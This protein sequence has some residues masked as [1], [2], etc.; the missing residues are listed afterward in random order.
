VTVASFLN[1]CRACDQDFA[2]LEAFDRHRVGVHQYTFQEGMRMVPSREDG[3]R[4]LHP[5]EM[6]GRGMS[7]NPMGRWQIDARVERAR[8]A[9]SAIGE[10]SGSDR[11]ASD[12]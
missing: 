12:G 10:T 2:S 11:K 8:K 9:F 1:L 3:R 5:E 6:P 7:V 4:C